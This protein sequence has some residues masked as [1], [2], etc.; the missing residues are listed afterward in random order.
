LLVTGVSGVGKSSL[1]RVL[2]GLWPL[3]AGQLTRPLRVGR[4]GILFLPQRSYIAAGSLRDQ[5]LYPL[6]AVAA[7]EAGAQ[8]QGQGQQ[9]DAE[10]ARVLQ[11]VGLGHLQQRW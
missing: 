4:G 7:S 1:L 3:D 10:V 5:V 9:Q 6:P 8:Q 11:A 2:A